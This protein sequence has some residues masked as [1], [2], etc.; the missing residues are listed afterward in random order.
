MKKKYL[1]IEFSK[2]YFSRRLNVKIT[3]I[4]F[5]L[6]K[7]YDWSCYNDCPYVV[8]VPAISIKFL[9]GWYYNIGLC[10]LLK[11]END[12]YGYPERMINV[13][14]SQNRNLCFFKSKEEKITGIV[15][16]ANFYRSEMTKIANALLE[17]DP[18]D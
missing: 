17:D 11:L 5:V 16:K 3:D 8:Y 6:V 12:V 7:S 2:K 4:R 13:R 9:P 18:S 14:F 10:R 15:K 1:T